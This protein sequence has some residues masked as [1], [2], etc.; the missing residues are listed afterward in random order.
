M[1]V[2]DPRNWSLGAP[3]DEG[4]KWYQWR[5]PFQL[6]IRAIWGNLDKVLVDFHDMKHRMDVDHYDF[7]LVEQKVVPDA[8]AAD[9][10]FTHVSYK[11]FMVIHQY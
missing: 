2:P 6:H 11:L 7:A 8:V 5:R 4:R 1:Q 10:G 9:Y 3:K